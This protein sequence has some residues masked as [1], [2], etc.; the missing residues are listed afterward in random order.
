MSVNIRTANN[1]QTVQDTIKTAIRHALEDV[2]DAVVT[3][4]QDN[5]DEQD[6]V[7]TG[8]LKGSVEYG[9][10]NDERIAIGTNVEYGIYVEYGTGKY[11][12]K[13]GRQTPWVY[14]DSNGNF[15]MTEGM[16]PRPY[17]KP[18]VTEHKEKIK[19]FIENKIQDEFN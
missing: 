16:R 6:A 7:D 2:G 5:L 3:W 13:G 11:A 19:Q 17:L 4:A 9:F 15:R 8:R 12:E 18:S 10:V 1:V 14:K